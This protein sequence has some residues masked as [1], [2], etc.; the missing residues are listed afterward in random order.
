[1]F[2]KIKKAALPSGQGKTMHFAKYHQYR[3]LSNAFLPAARKTPLNPSNRFTMSD[4][5]SGRGRNG[6][7]K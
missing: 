2:A 1:M 7:G 6:G 5:V 3:N 4:K